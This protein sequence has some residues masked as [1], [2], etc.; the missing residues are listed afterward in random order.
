MGLIKDAERCLEVKARQLPSVNT[1]VRRTSLITRKDRDKDRVPMKS[2][3]VWRTQSPQS[4]RKSRAQ[5][6]NQRQE[7]CGKHKHRL[8]HA[9]KK[10][11]MDW[12]F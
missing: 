9:R 6:E 3:R 12:E 7:F 5:E 10:K 11:R 8:G 1:H 2:S 4:R